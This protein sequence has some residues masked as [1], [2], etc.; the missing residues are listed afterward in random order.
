[1][2][3]SCPRAAIWA[4]APV[5]KGWSASSSAGDR[6][7]LGCW[8]MGAGMKR[9]PGGFATAADPAEGTSG[10]SMLEGALQHEAD[11][12]QLPAK[13]LFNPCYIK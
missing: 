10:G 4:G 2:S 1:M 6:A 5:S 8:A 3:W 7:A 13:S 12:V 11:V 9:L